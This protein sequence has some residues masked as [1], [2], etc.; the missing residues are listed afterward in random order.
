MRGGR[1]PTAAA[2]ARAL[3]TAAGQ[4][5]ERAALKCAPRRVLYGHVNP[6]L[7]ASWYVLAALESAYPHLPLATLARWSGL[8]FHPA[9]AIMPLLVRQR[10]AA[11]WNAPLEGLIF[12]EVA[13]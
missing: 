12:A 5:D 6:T 3:W 2:I 7:R 4:F 9:Q 13:R 1:Y 11:D 8:H 10:R